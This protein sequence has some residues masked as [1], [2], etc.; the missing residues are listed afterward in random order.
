MKLTKTVTSGGRPAYYASEVD[1]Y[2]AQLE[3]E[4]IALEDAKYC[5]EDEL[6]C[7]ITSELFAASVVNGVRL[8]PWQAV[9]KALKAENERYKDALYSIAGINVGPS[10]M[11][12]A[13]KE[14]MLA[15]KHR[16]KEALRGE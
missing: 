11:I 13:W 7:D 9:A 1:E 6:P 2:I 4:L 10:H 12:R 14:M 3:A 16:A 8:Y 15:A 5:Y